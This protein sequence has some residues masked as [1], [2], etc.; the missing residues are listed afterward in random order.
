MDA[1]QKPLKWLLAVVFVLIGVWS[2]APPRPLPADAPL[3]EF[4]RSEP[5]STSA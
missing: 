1:G 4:P 5:S 3:T 2:L